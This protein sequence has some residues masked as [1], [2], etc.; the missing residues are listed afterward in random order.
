METRAE[1]EG[2]LISIKPGSGKVVD[3]FSRAV[4]SAAAFLG[5]QVI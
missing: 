1:D 4:S 2:E 5:E 3:F